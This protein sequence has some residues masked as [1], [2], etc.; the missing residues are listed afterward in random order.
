[1]SQG[2]RGGY[3]AVFYNTTPGFGS[4]SVSIGGLLAGTRLGDGEPTTTQDAGGQE[5]STGYNQP[6]EVHTSQVTAAFITNLIAAQNNCTPI[7]FKYYATGGT[8]VLTGPTRVTVKTTGAEPGQLH[9]YIIGHTQF[10]ND[11]GD[12]VTYG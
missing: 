12:A 2:V 5:I 10:A 1:M 11:A 9:R 6:G 3:T 7:Y 8:P 4:S